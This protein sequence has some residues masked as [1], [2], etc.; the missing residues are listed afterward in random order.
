[1]KY[2]LNLKNNVLYGWAYNVMENYS[3]DDIVY[4]GKDSDFIKGKS[5]FTKNDDGTYTLDNS[6]DYDSDWLAEQE[7]IKAESEKESTIIE[8][9][10][11]LTDTDYVITKLNELKLED[12]DEYETEKAKY[13][14]ILA[15]R[16]E[17][18]SK[19]NELETETN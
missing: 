1:M 2:S 10:Q 16:K 9:K 6:Q 19:I 15:K 5:R 11:Y 13:A 14:D 7:S 4:E 12:E 3:D 17:C 8:L 18:R